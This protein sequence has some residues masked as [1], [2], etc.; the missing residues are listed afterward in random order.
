MS[1][2]LVD[3][4]QA[5]TQLSQ[6]HFS[7]WIQNNGL[8]LT[9]GSAFPKYRVRVTSGIDSEWFRVDSPFVEREKD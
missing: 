6:A 5:A 2:G 8:R 4:N 3:A 7:P 9:A 1:T